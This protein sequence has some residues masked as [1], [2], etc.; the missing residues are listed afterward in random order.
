[1]IRTR[2]TYH[3]PSQ[4]EE[5]CALLGEHGDDATVLGGGTMLVPIMVR[6]ERSASHVVDLRRLGLTQITPRDGE[7][8]IGAKATYADVLSSTALRDRAPLLPMA[9][10]GITGGAQIRNVGTIGG[11]ASYAN[12]SSDVPACLVALGARMRVHGPSGARE[13]SAEQFFV[14]AFRSDLGRGEILTAIVIPEVA[15]SAG[16][17]KLKLCESSWPIATA[18][19][20]VDNGRKAA[21]VTLGGVCRTPLR[22]GIGSLLD[23]EGRVHVTD[24]DLD[25]LVREQL[26]ELWED[27]L[28]PASYRRDVAAVVARRALEQSE[29]VYT[30]HE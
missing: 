27:E 15:G 1:M 14:D 6:G 30:D 11:S 12:P 23:G 8:E 20:I 9:A 2:L 17:Y 7:V 16:Y 26:D 4:I 13:V 3:S 22:I 29:E 28:A 18:A 21:S 10:A 19:A 5:A 25:D 24:Q